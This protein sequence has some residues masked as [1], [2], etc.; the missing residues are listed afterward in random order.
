MHVRAWLSATSYA[1]FSSPAFQVDLSDP[2]PSLL[3]RV[4]EAATGAGA[5]SVDVDYMRREA[6]QWGLVFLTMGAVVALGTDPV[7]AR[8]TR[9][10]Q[11]T[12]GDK[13]SL[14]SYH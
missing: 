7:L 12:Q 13:F 4:T 10:H 8:L 1:L 3:Q 6:R 9:M 5:S 11:Y 2:P 14:F